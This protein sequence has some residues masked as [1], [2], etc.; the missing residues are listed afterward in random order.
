MNSKISSWP[1]GAVL[2]CT[3]TRGIQA[4][5]FPSS[6]LSSL[7]EASIFT[8]YKR[9]TPL[10]VFSALRI[11]NVKFAWK[12]QIGECNA[13]RTVSEIKE[14]NVILGKFE[15]FEAKTFNSPCQLNLE[16]LSDFFVWKVLENT[17][18]VHVLFAYTRMDLLSWAMLGT[19]R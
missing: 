6:D 18:Q 1:R 3:P 8:S 13:L 15:Q 2:G 7:A 12:Q 9:K 16:C 14:Y 10:G 4:T 17:C 11:P 5:S 19:S